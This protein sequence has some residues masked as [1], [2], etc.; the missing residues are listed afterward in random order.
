MQT[1]EK[2]TKGSNSLYKDLGEALEGLLYPFLMPEEATIS[3]KGM[4]SKGGG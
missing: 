1:R 4:I 3:S 2:A